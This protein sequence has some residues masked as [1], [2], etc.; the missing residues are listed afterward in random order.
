VRAGAEVVHQ[1]GELARLARKHV[2][3]ACIDRAQVTTRAPSEM[4]ARDAHECAT[5]RGWNHH[6]AHRHLAVRQRR[7][8]R[9][10]RDTERS[11][12]ASAGSP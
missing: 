5:R 9:R 10:E 7:L 3:V 2:Q 6:N 12:A 4:A 1:A 11:A 8:D